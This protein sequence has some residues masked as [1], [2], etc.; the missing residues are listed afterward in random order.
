MGRDI[1]AVLL[2]FDETLALERPTAERLIEDICSETE[3]RHG[4]APDALR[5]S[6]FAE[7]RKLWFAHELRPF[8]KQVGISSWEGL[9]G[10]FVGDSDELTALRAWT[11]VYR[12]RAWANA[13]AVHGCDDTSLADELAE[14]YYEVRA[15]THVRFPETC[16]VLDALKG[17]YRLGVVTNGASDMQR[18]KLSGA[19]LDTYFDAVV[20]GGDVRARKPD[21]APF[22]RALSLLDVSPDAAVM[23]GDSIEGDV[24]GA[25][26][27][28]ICAVWLNRPGRA[29]DTDITPDHEIESLTSLLAILGLH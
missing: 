10:R 25:Q 16:E 29:N 5:D 13:L 8:C 23:V 3:N 4:L 18:T 21:P 15:Q 11:A 2:D 20:A 1:T 6:V 12:P 26:D 7:A 27:M 17:R 24:K 14:R 22:E 19:E 9:W 28:G